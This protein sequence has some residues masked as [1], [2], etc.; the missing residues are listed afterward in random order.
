MVA[1]VV[2]SVIGG[3]LYPTRFEIVLLP[4]RQFGDPI[5]REALRSYSEWSSLPLDEPLLWALVVLV[6][7][8]LI[9]AVRQRRVASAAAIVALA[10]MG[11]SGSR[12]API[13]AV[14]LV[15]FAASA[16]REFGTLELPSGR[17]ARLTG[18]AAA[19]IAAATLVYCVTV[20]SYRD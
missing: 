9:G 14:S 20:P 10:A 17:A 6:A 1:S 15:I 13:A 7:V 3:A 8:A 11:Y 4:T 5:E 12:L 18:V 19:L 2:G 16:M